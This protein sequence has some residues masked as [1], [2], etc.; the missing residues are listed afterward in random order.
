MEE[1]DEESDDESLELELELE[2]LPLLDACRFF[3]PF[4][5]FSFLLFFSSG[6]SFGGIRFLERRN[7]M[8]LS[9]SS[10]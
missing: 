10:W 3:F 6:T 8:E 9:A 4:F 1:S 5:F 7:S 2:L